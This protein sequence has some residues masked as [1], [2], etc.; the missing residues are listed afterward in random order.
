MSDG[1]SRIFLS[2]GNGI[3]P[4]PGPGSSPPPELGESTVRLAVQPGGSLA[5]ADFFS[6]A[7]APTLNLADTDLGAGGP[8]GLPFGSSTYPDLLVQTGKDGRVFLLNRDNLGGRRQGPNGTDAAVSTNGP[9]QG[10]WGHPAA[11]GD[12][13]TVTSGNS[14]SANDYVYYVGA[15]DYLR[16]L[17]FQLNSSGTPLLVPVEIAAKLL[18]G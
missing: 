10:E 17:K 9:Y 15:N 3:S 14:G 2:T 16:A 6:P 1:S 4:A 11:F 7:N 8:V 12:T 5:A 18:A 13:T